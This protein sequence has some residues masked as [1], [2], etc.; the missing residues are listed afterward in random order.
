MWPNQP[1]QKV[2][3]ATAEES[4]IKYSCNTHTHT[5]LQYLDFSKIQCVSIISIIHILTVSESA[6][7]G[8][9]VQS[10]L[11][12]RLLVLPVRHNDILISAVYAVNC[13]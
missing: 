11:Q 13:E 10:H 1:K 5:K 9:L 8:N 6:N 4:L 7:D 12:M 3:V 2:R